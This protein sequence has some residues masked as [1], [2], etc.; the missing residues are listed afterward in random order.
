M[1]MFPQFS[2]D[3]TESRA[4][5]RSVL[6]ELESTSDTAD[7]FVSMNE[8]HAALEI[9]LLWKVDRRG[10]D[11]LASTIHGLVPR[12][13][14]STP[15]RLVTQTLIDFEQDEIID[16]VERTLRHYE[17]WQ[18]SKLFR[19][20]A[21]RSNAECF[22]LYARSLMSSSDRA[23]TATAKQVLNTY[24]LGSALLDA[25]EMTK[26]RSWMASH[27][28]LTD[29]DRARRSLD[30]LLRAPR[31]PHVD[32]EQNLRTRLRIALEI[33]GQMR[34]YDHAFP[35]WEQT[36][37]FEHEVDVYVHT[38]RRVGRR[39]PDPSIVGSFKR[40]FGDTK[41]AALLEQAGLDHGMAHLERE[42]PTV[43]AA[44]ASSDEV[45]ESDIR[46]VYGAET[47]IVIEDETVA[48]FNEMSN[49]DKMHYKIHAVHELARTRKPYDLV[50]RIRPDRFM[51]DRNGRIRWR[52]VLDESRSDRRIFTEE[53]T[54]LRENLIIGDQL[55]V[56][57]P[58]LMDV[59]ASSW[60]RHTSGELHRLYG[61][62]RVLTGHSSLAYTLLYELI[63]V[64]RLPD[65]ASGRPIDPSTVDKEVLR[66]QVSTDIS[67]RSATKLDH[68]ILACL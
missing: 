6:G 4:A 48:P 56:G 63:D 26:F 1:T 18:L 66:R 61:V 22:R 21:F 43:F 8:L 14:N 11:K 19:Y 41:A 12:T 45:T 53:D 15:F 65:L 51:D 49:Q 32:P 30:R 46:D 23:E 16:R 38:W 28:P 9:S 24:I 57:T 35:T 68:Q 54:G 40:R 36:G 47:T 27:A 64:Q 31:P 39:Y 2:N 5:I 33:S 10:Y 62:P 50:V 58:E 34:G 29:D 7:R 42:Y 3:L 67:G 17:P 25:D 60:D 44:L 37:I 55:A 59:Y 52:Q 13:R 20:P